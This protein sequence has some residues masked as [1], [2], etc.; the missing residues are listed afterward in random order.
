[1]IIVSVTV[2]FVIYFGVLNQI[3]HYG[4]PVRSNN[5][6]SIYKVQYFKFE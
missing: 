3:L 5:S 1:M 4:L 6:V 2:S